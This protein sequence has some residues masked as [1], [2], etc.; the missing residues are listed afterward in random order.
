C[1][2]YSIE[3]ALLDELKELEQRLSKHGPY[4]NG[5]EITA[6]DLSL[7]PKLYHLTVALRHF[8]EWNVPKKLTHVHKYIKV[9]DLLISV[10]DIS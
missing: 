4:F 7:A 2:K 3:E 8:K 5:G 6:V 10:L 1:K 9:R